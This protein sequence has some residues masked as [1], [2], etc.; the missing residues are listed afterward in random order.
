MAW[1][2]VVARAGR[3]LAGGTQ[4]TASM[5]SQSQLPATE[6]ADLC[7]YV[8][9]SASHCDGVRSLA[10]GSAQGHIQPVGTVRHGGALWRPATMSCDND[11]LTPRSPCISTVVPSRFSR[12]SPKSALRKRRID[13]AAGGTGDEVT[14]LITDHLVPVATE[15]G[16]EEFR[17]SLSVRFPVT[18]VCA[19]PMWRARVFEAIKLA[20]VSPT[21][22][23]ASP[24]TSAVTAFSRNFSVPAGYRGYPWHLFSACVRFNQDGRPVGPCFGSLR[25][26]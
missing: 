11:P 13:D 25:P 17:K 6:P 2:Q 26:I 4:R 15:V 16:D 3:G 1:R 7:I 24:Q 18:A 23:G 9:R 20:N 10:P 19:A 21:R 12:P 14:S 5:P 8:G 22:A